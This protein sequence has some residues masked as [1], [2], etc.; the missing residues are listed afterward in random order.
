MEYDLNMKPGASMDPL[1][2]LDPLEWT[3]HLEQRNLPHGCGGNPLRLRLQADLLQGHVLVRQLVLGL[4]EA[5]TYGIESMQLRLTIQWI[6]YRFCRN[7][8]FKYGINIYVL[9]TDFIR[10]RGRYAER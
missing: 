5:A 6:M 1:N 4:S 8:T 7:H 10:I 2:G 3:L 9:K